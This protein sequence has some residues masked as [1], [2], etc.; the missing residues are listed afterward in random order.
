[1]RQADRQTAFF[2]LHYC[3]LMRNM[4]CCH[5]MQKGWCEGF[6]GEFQSSTEKG[7]FCLKIEE[8]KQDA[9]SRKIW[10]AEVEVLDM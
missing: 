5:S 3:K 6:F 8:K 1:M 2:T 7:V 10:E 9:S 4:W